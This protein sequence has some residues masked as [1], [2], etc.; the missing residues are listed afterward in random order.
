MPTVETA[1]VYRAAGGRRYF[2][3]LAALRAEAK[4]VILS[5][6]N[7]EPVDLETGYPGWGCRFHA[8]PDYYKRV[9]DRLVRRIQRATKETP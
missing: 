6:C 3:K 4:A 1:R 9:R 2:T 8:D 5:A 7:C